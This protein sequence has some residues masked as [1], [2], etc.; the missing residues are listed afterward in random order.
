MD[1]VFEPWGWDEVVETQRLLEILDGLR[2]PV[3]ELEEAA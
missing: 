2:E 3:D 1:D